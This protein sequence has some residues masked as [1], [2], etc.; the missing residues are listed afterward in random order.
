[1]K[2][3]SFLAAMFL[4]FVPLYAGAAPYPFELGEDLIVIEKRLFNNVQISPSRESLVPYIRFLNYQGRSEEAL[5]TLRD[6]K[7]EDS[8]PDLKVLW[9][10]MKYFNGDTD[11]LREL[12]QSI[13]PDKKS[14][15]IASREILIRLDFLEGKL[16]Q[17]SQGCLDLVK[18]DPANLSAFCFQ[19]QIL[20]RY[21]RCDEALRMLEQA[22]LVHP[23]DISIL[24][25]RALVFD[26]LGRVEDSGNLRRSMVRLIEA[27]TPDSPE[28]LVMASSAMR[29]LGEFRAANQCLQ[30][31]LRYYP[32]DPYVLLEKIR[33]F[34]ATSGFRDS[35]GAI[36]N[37]LERYPNCSMAYFE[38]GETLWQT[39]KP[40]N[41]IMG[42]CGKVLSLDPAMTE[43]GN[44]LALCHI[45]RKEWEEADDILE[46]NKK[47]NPANRQTF[48]IQKI[49]DLLRKG[50][51]KPLDPESQNLVEESD[52]DSFLLL[53]EILFFRGE[54]P[55]SRAWFDLA[56]EKEPGNPR[57]LRSA[58]ETCLRLGDFS[59]AY[60]LLKRE[61]TKNRYDLQTKNML[62]LLESFEKGILIQGD[63]TSSDSIRIGCQPEDEALGE[64]ALFLSRGFLDNLKNRFHIS[65]EKPVHIQILDSRGDISA[66]EAGLASFGCGCSS[67]GVLGLLTY[68][69]NILLLSPRAAGGLD[70]RYR[71]DE[72]LY[73]GLS[74]ISIDPVHQG[75]APLWI[76][77]GVS[78]YLAY[79]YIP[80][81]VPVNLDW[82]I[83]FL[84]EEKPPSI[85]SL[86]NPNIPEAHIFNRV[87]SW[88]IIRQWAEKYGFAH[89]KN[90]LSLIGENEDWKKAASAVF[91]NPFPDLETEILG[92]ILSR[93]PDVKI[94][95]QPS[96]API[97]ELAEKARYSNEAKIE[98]ARSYVS[99]RRFDE[100]LKI[101]SPITEG[102]DPSAPALF[103]A[104]RAF[105]EKGN[106]QK[107][108]DYIQTALDLE[109]LQEQD[110]ATAEDYEALGFALYELGERESAL[111]AFRN[112]IKRNPFDSRKN[113]AFGKCLEILGSQNPKPDEYF[114]LLEERLPSRPNDIEIRHEL[115]KRHLSLEKEQQAFHILQSSAGINPS[116]VSVHRLL[117]PLAFK[118]G[119][120]EQSWASYRMILL[121]NRN[122][123][124]ALNGLKQCEEK[125]GVTF[126]DK[127]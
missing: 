111:D 123:A 32:A 84:K 90:F 35:M 127:K 36:K 49:F 101:L 47:A 13:S 28:G 48:R 27:G 29:H 74:H 97:Q 31:A 96:C 50:A 33:L 87:Y 64:Y 79:E 117:A 57:I 98:L 22:E 43:A 24:E 55:E 46:K 102:G 54:Y 67:P 121:K 16:E 110:S 58:G 44:R 89:V 11:N 56:L 120:I 73:R 34:R 88:L 8:D 94:T 25:I 65:P 9:C 69:A 105:R 12:A 114:K 23:K 68:D 41:V 115:A 2:F 85:A 78:R 63:E 71:F 124:F 45:V 20:L 70:E 92:G 109:K 1:M 81:A 37:L 76:K 51:T 93:Y 21:G 60:S 19:A 126:L 108:R 99:A 53:G 125:L 3:H 18:I 39:R 17:C 75:F 14:A 122:D 4:F 100:A 7:M 40:M 30:L 119:D 107:A 52:P 38:A 15:R 66:A 113:G 61:F 103:I 59:G 82:M 77:E 86:D 104:G 112:S 10:E 72:A 95:P 118:L 106:F 91:E 83:G 42:I 5:Q 116:L 62:V 80:D 6:F 26:A